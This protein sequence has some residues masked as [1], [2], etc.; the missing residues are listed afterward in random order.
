MLRGG[1]SFF[2]T[3]IKG[4]PL[5][6]ALWHSCGNLSDFVSKLVNA[7][8]L[9]INHYQFIY[10]KK[11]LERRVRRGSALDF[12]DQQSY[13]SIDLNILPSIHN[14][15]HDYTMTRVRDAFHELLE[16]RPSQPRKQVASECVALEGTVTGVLV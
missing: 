13:A 6:E 5:R 15:T 7:N 10:G 4:K 16:N 12:K 8:V 11:S 2:D 14:E 1:R 3:R 9:R